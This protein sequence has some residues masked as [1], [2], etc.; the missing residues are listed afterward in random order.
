MGTVN[1]R[2]QRARA[3]ARF[4]AQAILDGRRLVLEEVHE[5]GQAHVEL[6]LSANDET[7]VRGKVDE[8]RRAELDGE[9]RRELI[10]VYAERKSFAIELDG[11]EQRDDV[12]PEEALHHRYVDP[13][14][15]TRVPEVRACPDP[16]LRRSHGVGVGEEQSVPRQL[17]H[18]EITDM[19]VGLDGEREGRCIR[20]PP[21]KCVAD[22]NASFAREGRD[23]VADPM[24]QRNP[25]R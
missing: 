20:R 15:P 11:P 21:A 7:P 13:V 19:S 17:A 12:L 9:L 22:R 2:R 24:D 14:H 6:R 18:Q 8:L 23:L 10:G 25:D 3:V 5:V 16:R 1:S 4:A